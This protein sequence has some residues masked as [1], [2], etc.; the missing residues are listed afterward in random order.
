MTDNMK[1]CLVPLAC[2]VVVTFFGFMHH[3]E[4]LTIVGCVVTIA[5]GV[6]I[7]SKK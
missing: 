1:I 4:L 5:S 2:G 3:N 6:A 7:W